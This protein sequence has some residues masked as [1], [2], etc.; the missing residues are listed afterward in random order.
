MTAVLH[1]RADLALVEIMNSS[2]GEE[3]PWSK[4]RTNHLPNIFGKREDVRVPLEVRSEFQT[5]VSFKAFSLL[6]SGFIHYHRGK[7]RGSP[8]MMEGEKF[9]FG[10]VEGHKPSLTPLD[11]FLQVGGKIRGI[12]RFRCLLVDS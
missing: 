8:V 11:N 6:K 7:R 1:F 9:G 4:E 10:R 5:Q 12:V 3:F 2:R